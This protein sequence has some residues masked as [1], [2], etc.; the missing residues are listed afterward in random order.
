MAKHNKADSSDPTKGSFKGKL[1]QPKDNISDIKKTD[2][3]IN[4]L[5]KTEA[6]PSE[7]LRKLVEDE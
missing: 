6:N 1:P 2:D 3:K 7:R 4:R 5:N